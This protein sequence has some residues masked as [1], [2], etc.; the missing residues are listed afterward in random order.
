MVVAE[1]APTAPPSHP[2]RCPGTSA[3]FDD[4]AAWGDGWL[5]IEGYGDIDRH[6]PALRAAFERHGRDPDTAMVTVYSSNGDPQTLHRY[7]KAGVQRV[8]VG[9][10]PADEHTVLTALDNQVRRLSGLLDG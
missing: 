8:V 3:V 10:P 5:P 7:R 4:I 6:V 9:L 2:S 1:T